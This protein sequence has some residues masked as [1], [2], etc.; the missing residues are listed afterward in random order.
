MKL[1]L[2]SVEF[3]AEGIGSQARLVGAVGV[4]ALGFLQFEDPLLSDLKLADRFP[5]RALELG[6]ALEATP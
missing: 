1:R 2:N 6:D 3:L 4:T 5:H